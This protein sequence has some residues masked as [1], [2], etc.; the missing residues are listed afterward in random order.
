MPAYAGMRLGIDAGIT[1]GAA[2]VSVTGG[3]NVGAELGIVAGAAAEADLLWTPAAGLT[4]QATLR[5]SAEPRLRFSLGAFV[6]A[7]V[8]LIL[9][10]FTVYRKDWQLAAFEFGPALRLGI[11]APIAYRSESGVDFD[12]NAIRFQLPSIA[13]HELVTGLL[14]T[15]GREEMHRR[16]E[17][18][19]GGGQDG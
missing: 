14:G 1:G 19:P 16:L 13:A 3:M 9:T 10:S 2:T 12:F 17:W 15:Q 8:S 11:E 4:L 6:R 18:A 7:D 5:A